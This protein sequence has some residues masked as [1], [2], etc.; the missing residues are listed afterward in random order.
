MSAA[1][2]LD[3]T[4]MKYGLLLETAQTQQELVATGLQELRDHAR[5][6]DGIVRAEIR[7][8]LIDELGEVV[9][10]SERAVATLRALERRARLRFLLST[11][12]TALLSGAM[13]A[14]AAWWL[15]PTSA[16]INALRSRRDQLA[17]ELTTLQRNG[18]LIDLR[19]CGSG[20]RWCVR[21]DRK[22]PVY[23]DE[24][25]YLVVKGY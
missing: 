5:G 15:L 3:E 1:A 25:D 20:Q 14:A 8:T 9:Q 23:G 11:L 22:A 16:E 13:T 21:I 10:E 19:R 6:L 17:G 12:V 7:Q 2:P 24:S 4:T 18:G